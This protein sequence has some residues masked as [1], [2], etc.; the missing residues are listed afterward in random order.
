V[1]YF[2]TNYIPKC[3]LAEHGSAEATAVFQQN[4]GNIG[5]SRLGRVEWHAT[6]RR[7]LIANE[8]SPA[9][10]AVIR[11]QMD[12]DEAAGLWIWLP[13]EEALLDGLAA[14]LRATPYLGGLKTLDAVHL[15]S[16]R[17]AGMTDLYSNDGQVKA[18][19]PIFGLVSNDVIPVVP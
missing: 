9:E 15:E 11:T 8:L 4:A 1:I 14:W 12:A 10:V 13:F 7:K 17:L 2:D 6:I 3:Y 16:A 19:A 18:A 5:C